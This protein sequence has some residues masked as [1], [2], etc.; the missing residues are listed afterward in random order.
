MTPEN[1]DK[2]VRNKGRVRTITGPDKKF[3]LEKNEYRHAC[4]IRGEMHLGE[5]K[6]KKEQDGKK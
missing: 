1:F 4:F 5:I 3:G 2:C 6:Q